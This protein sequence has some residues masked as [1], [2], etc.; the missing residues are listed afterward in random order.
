MKWNLKI[1]YKDRTEP[2]KVVEGTF[3]EVVNKV[4]DLQK[5]DPDI[6]GFYISKAD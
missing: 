4:T 1:V 5:F 2:T 6:E 3:Q